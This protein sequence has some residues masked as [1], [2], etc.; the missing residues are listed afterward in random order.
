MGELLLQV[1]VNLLQHVG[2]VGPP[3]EGPMEPDPDHLLEPDAV[4]A[5]QL[6]QGGPVPARGAADQLLVAGVGTPVVHRSA[7]SRSPGPDRPRDPP[8]LDIPA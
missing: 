4:A 8:P 6:G 2:R 5:E 7:P 3:L 1:E